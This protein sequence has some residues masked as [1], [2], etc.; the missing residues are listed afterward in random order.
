MTWTGG[1]IA[2][3]IV[4]VVGW[5]ENTSCAGGPGATL[6]EELVAFKVDVV[7]PNV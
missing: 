2:A 7:T 3:P 4:V 5:P 6:N 1:V